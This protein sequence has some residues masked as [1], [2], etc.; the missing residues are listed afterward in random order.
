MSEELPAAG[1]H[2]QRHPYLNQDL[3]IFSID[4]LANYLNASADNRLDVP[5]GA[6][7]AKGVFIDEAIEALDGTKGAGGITLD[8]K[9]Q[10]VWE[11]HTDCR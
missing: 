2:A 4:A 10:A 6:I 7:E 5:I 9:T 3:K 11:R 1:R 8:Y